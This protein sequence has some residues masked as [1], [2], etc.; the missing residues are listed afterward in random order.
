MMTKDEALK[1]AI[2]QLWAC[3]MLMNLD[4]S[5]YLYENVIAAH[6][7]CKE[8]LEQPAQ[9][10][11]AWI[12][13]WKNMFGNHKDIVF[14]ETDGYSPLY[15][16]PHQWQGLTDSDVQAMWKFYDGKYYDFYTAIQQALKDKNT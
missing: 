7:A 6:D 11:V 8:A 5:D 1:M 14:I 9:Q 10:P 12:K 13:Q 16:H 3:S 15:T 4:H 2:E